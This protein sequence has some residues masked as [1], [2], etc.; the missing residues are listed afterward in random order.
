LGPNEFLSLEKAKKLLETTRERTEMANSQ[1]HKVPVRDYFIVHIALSTGLRVMEI[2][3]LNCGDVFIQDA[4]CSILIRRGKGGKQR[5]VRFKGFFKKHCEE[6]IF[7]KQTV[8]ESTDT[9][10]PLLLSSNSGPHISTNFG[11]A[12]MK[13]QDEIFHRELTGL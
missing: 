6:F 13:F 4:V 9:T 12:L 8:G 10:V 3:Q 2:S 1:E 11:V 7:L 5:L